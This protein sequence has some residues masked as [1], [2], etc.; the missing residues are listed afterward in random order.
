MGVGKILL[1]LIEIKDFT[2]QK[3]IFRKNFFWEKMCKCP[4]KKD[5]EF[6]KPITLNQLPVLDRYAIIGKN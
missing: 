4:F 3:K 5:E 6:S 2:S 1:F